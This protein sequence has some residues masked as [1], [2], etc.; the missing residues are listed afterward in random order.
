MPLPL[1]IQD[2]N[3]HLRGWANY[4]DW[5]YPRMAFRAI[6]NYVR[7]RLARHMNRRSQRRFHLPEGQ[8]YYSY[9]AHAGLLRS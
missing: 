6:N 8:T 5:G 1:L 7:E 3:R 4:F 9:L 2:I